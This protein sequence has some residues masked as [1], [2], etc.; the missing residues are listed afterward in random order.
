MEINEIT[1]IIVDRAINV[2]RNLGPGLLENTYEACL[3][4]E[5]LEAG[6]NVEP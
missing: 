5:L 2:H 6:L 1:G 4:Y 3:E